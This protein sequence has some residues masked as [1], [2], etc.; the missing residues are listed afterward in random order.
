MVQIRRKK[1]TTKKSTL[2]ESIE[3]SEIDRGFLLPGDKKIAKEDLPE[4]F[5]LRRTPVTEADDDELES[6]ALWIIKYA[7][8]EGTVTNQA[9]LDQDDKLDCI[10]NLDPSV[11]EDRKKAVIKSIK[12]VLQFI[13]VRSN[14]FEPTFI[15]FY[16]KEDI[17][18]LLTM[19]NLWR[20]YDF[21]EKWCHLSE[22]K[23]KIYDLMRRMREYQEL[24]D[25]LTAKRRPISDADLME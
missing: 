1:D 23:N 22:K 9:D 5:Q 13:R 12:K 19:N 8:E 6:E 21:D 14:S 2:L 24:S 17:D 10:M 18:N 25:D 4:R 15:G 3:P 20:V 7:F 16:R 11:Y